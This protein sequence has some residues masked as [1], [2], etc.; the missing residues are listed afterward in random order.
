MDPQVA[1]NIVA[2]QQSVE[3]LI[4]EAAA[5]PELLSQPYEEFARITDMVK[6]LCH[7]DAAQFSSE[8][9]AVADTFE[10]ACIAFF[11]S[12]YLLCM[13]CVR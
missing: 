6:R 3:N 13:A 10:Y 11:C 2:L 4:F 9:V 7:F 1:A 12:R 5:D 8:N